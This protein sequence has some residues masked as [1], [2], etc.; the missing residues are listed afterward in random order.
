LTPPTRELLV[1]G[2]GEI[3]AIARAR[4]VP[5]PE[6][7]IARTLAILDGVNPAG[8]SSLQRDI[9]AGKRSELDEWTGAVVRLGARAQVPTPLHDFLYAALL[10]QERRARGELAF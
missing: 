4:G 9:G 1:T 2:M 3:E 8:T 5:L 10:P 7:V 6:D